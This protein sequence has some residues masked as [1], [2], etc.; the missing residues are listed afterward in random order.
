MNDG[1]TN[2]SREINNTNSG[3]LTNQAGYLDVQVDN[4]QLME[5]SNGLDDLPSELCRLP[6]VDVLSLRQELEQLST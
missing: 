5:K 6:L 3:M 2:V 4:A 1:N